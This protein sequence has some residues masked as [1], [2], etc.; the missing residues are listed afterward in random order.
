M[1]ESAF[2]NRPENQAVSQEVVDFDEDE[3][4]APIKD[5]YH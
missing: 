1:D 2:L 4:I 3:P 5:V